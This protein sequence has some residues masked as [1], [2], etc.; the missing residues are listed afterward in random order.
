[1]DKVSD[2]TGAGA[3]ALLDSLPMT[4]WLLTD[5]DYDAGCFRDALEAKG[6][7]HCI[8]GRKSLE[9]PVKYDR[10]K[11]KRRNR[12]KIMFRRLK[13]QRRVATRRHMS[14]CLL[15]G[16]LLRYNRICSAYEA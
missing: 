3:S 2:D 6:I 13:D 1:L 4:Q 14:E 5:R 15:L 11:Y 16:N 9:K 8:P 12:I 7:R 10:R